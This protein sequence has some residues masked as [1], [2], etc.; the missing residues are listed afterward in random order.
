M[1][2]SLVILVIHTDV[3]ISLID[4]PRKSISRGQTLAPKI[5]IF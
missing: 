5:L 3:V 4:T 2:M 1:P